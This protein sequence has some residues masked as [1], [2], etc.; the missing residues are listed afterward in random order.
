MARDLFRKRRRIDEHNAIYH[1]G[2]EEDEE[3][4]VILLAILEDQD[5]ILKELRDLSRLRVPSQSKDL[6][7]LVSVQARIEHKLEDLMR[8]QKEFAMSMQDELNRMKSLVEANTN[9]TNSS[10]TLLNSIAAQLRNVADDPDEVRA[11]AD[12]IE[13]NSNALSSAVTANTPAATQPPTT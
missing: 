2:C 6:E 4:N 7:Q 3:H 13:A 8:A 12:Q 5:L 1:P 11:L 9:A 10:V